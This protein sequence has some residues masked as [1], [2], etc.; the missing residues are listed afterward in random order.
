MQ[1]LIKLVNKIMEYEKFES[2][3][4]IINL[5][6]EDIRFITEKVIQQF[7]QKL[8]ENNQRIITS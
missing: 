6:E 4:L 5:K 2:K 8:R 3:E 1:R 7:R